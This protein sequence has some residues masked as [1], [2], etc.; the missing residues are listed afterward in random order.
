MT[1]MLKPRYYCS[2]IIIDLVHQL[3]CGVL[4]AKN[5]VVFKCCGEISDVTAF[6]LWLLIR[7]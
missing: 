6:I 1:D 3:Q 5:G 2:D 4:Y 7:M